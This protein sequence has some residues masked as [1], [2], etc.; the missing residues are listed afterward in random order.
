MKSAQLVL[1]G[2]AT[3]DLDVP[4]GAQSGL[5]INVGQDV[6]KNATLELKLDFDANASLVQEGNGSWKL[7]PVLRLAP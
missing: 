4:S 5:K 1:D 3:Q 7:K 6:Q 2:G